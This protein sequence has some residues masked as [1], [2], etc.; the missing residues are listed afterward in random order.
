M[1][2]R[3]KTIGRGGEEEGEGRGRGGR[4]GGKG[5][6]EQFKYLCTVLLLILKAMSSFLHFIFRRCSAFCDIALCNNICINL[7][8][9]VLDYIDMEML[10]FRANG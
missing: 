6:N 10:G 4:E 2:S 1:T 5:G 7:S 8:Y 3:K 9:F